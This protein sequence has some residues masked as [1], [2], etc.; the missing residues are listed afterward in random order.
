MRRVQSGYFAPS[1][2]NASMRRS[3]RF[4]STIRPDAVTMR[5][6]RTSDRMNVLVTALGTAWKSVPTAP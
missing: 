3:N 4:Q 1:R 5:D 6:S 2:P